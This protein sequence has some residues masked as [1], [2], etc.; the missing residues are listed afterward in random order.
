MVLQLNDAG[1]WKM[2]GS[3]VASRPVSHAGPSRD[4]RGSSSEV[5]CQ[6]CERALP[7]VRLPPSWVSDVSVID[8]SPQDLTHRSPA[9]GFASAVRSQR[10]TGRSE[11]NQGWT[12]S[13]LK[14]FFSGESMGWEKTCFL[15]ESSF[16]AEFIRLCLFFSCR[17]GGGSG[18]KKYIAASFMPLMSLYLS[19]SS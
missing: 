9:V 5:S 18:E 13:E 10:S 11:L 17:L 15:C 1:L 12:S 8:V 2:T 14:L 3:A 16:S 4:G 7:V 6:W 19:Q